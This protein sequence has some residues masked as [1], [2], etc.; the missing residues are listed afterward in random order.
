MKVRK[1]G[2]EF[3]LYIGAD[4][5]W[6]MHAWSHVA[7]ENRMAWIATAHDVSA[8]DPFLDNEPSTV[9]YDAWR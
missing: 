1:G 8:A 5:R 9:V 2:Q 7:A 6:T 4:G 3:T